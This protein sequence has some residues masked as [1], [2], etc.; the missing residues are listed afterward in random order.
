MVPA[1]LGRLSSVRE[2]K[3]VGQEV[4]MPPPMPIPETEKVLNV[5]I[6]V[7]LVGSVVPTPNPVLST[8]E[9][10]KVWMALWKKLLWMLK[11]AGS[12]TLRIVR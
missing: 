7:M 10:M 12:L 1:K 11:P 9:R 8:A 2:F 6:V 4:G 5:V 3:D